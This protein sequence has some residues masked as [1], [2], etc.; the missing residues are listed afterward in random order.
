M[1]CERHV[2][3]YSSTPPAVRSTPHLAG[4]SRA[5]ITVVY[6]INGI[7]FRNMENAQ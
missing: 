4:Y 3:Y 2:T 5:G 6:V 7:I 1:Y